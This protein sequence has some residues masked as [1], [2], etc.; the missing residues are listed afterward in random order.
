MWWKFWQKRLL[1]TKQYLLEE[2]Q[3]CE[4]IEEQDLGCTLVA[5]RRRIEDVY[6]HS[7]S[8]RTTCAVKVS[9]Q[10]PVVDDTVH[11]TLIS[12]LNPV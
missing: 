10:I 12:I 4:N 11:S 5:W 1:L 7:I 2:G 3:I 6:D 8:E 9:E